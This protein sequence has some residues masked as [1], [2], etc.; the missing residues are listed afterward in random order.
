MAADSRTPSAA[1]M[2]PLNMPPVFDGFAS[3]GDSCAIG[4][5]PLRL[6]VM[7]GNALRRCACGGS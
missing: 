4:D 1:F 3:R 6:R 7:R 2:S 5:K